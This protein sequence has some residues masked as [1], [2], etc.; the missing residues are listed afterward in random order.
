LYIY[1][2]ILYIGV[3]L[4]IGGHYVYKAAKITTTMNTSREAMA[5]FNNKNHSYVISLEFH[6]ALSLLYC[7]L[8]FGSSFAVR[9]G[10]NFCFSI[11]IVHPDSLAIFFFLIFILST[12]RKLEKL[13]FSSF[14]KMSNGN[15]RN[16]HNIRSK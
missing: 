7:P 1:I 12:K 10:P 5:H 14:W 9:F 6:A 2:Y 3:C 16:Y 13:F 4:Y 8:P 15:T 11:L